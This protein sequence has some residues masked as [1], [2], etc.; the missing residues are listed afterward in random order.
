P[1][2]MKGYWKK[3]KETNDSLKNGWLYTGDLARQDEEGYFYIVGR[4]KELIITN[5]FNV[6]PQEI[7][8]VLFAHPDIK[9]SVVVLIKDEKRDELTK[10]FIVVVSDVKINEDELK[11][12]CYKNLTPY[13]DTK[14]FEEIAD[15]TINNVGKGLKKKLKDMDIK[16]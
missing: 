10:A 12:Y 3:E 4:K 7:E 16:K 9:E 2:V 13:K 8:S 14:Q 15:L 11:G 6:Y 1:Q 5:G